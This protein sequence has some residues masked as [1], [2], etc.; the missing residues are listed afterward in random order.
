MCEIQNHRVL[1]FMSHPASAHP[2]LTL[3]REPRWKIEDLTKSKNFCGTLHQKNKLHHFSEKRLG[4]IWCE[5]HFNY[6][7]SFKVRSIN[8]Q[9]ITR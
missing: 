8:T 4:V 3:G 9:Y 6:L 7:Q 1:D 5:V 2:P